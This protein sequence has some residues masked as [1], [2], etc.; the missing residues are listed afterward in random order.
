MNILIP[1]AGAGSRFSQAGY[2]L[3]K[4]LIDVNGKPM[5]QVVTGNLNM[6]AK[7]TYVVQQSHYEQYDLEHLLNLIS[8]GCNIVQV[9]GLTEGT[10]CTTLLARAF[11]DNDEPLIIANSDQ[12]I[13][14]D[15]NAFLDAMAADDLDGGIPTFEATSSKWCYAKLDEDGLVCEVVEKKPVSRF[16]A[17]GIFYW[18]HGNDYVR[19]TEDMIAKD[20]RTNNE[21][22]V[23]PA[24]NE[25]IADN[26]RIKVYDVR[27]MWSL[28]TPEDLTDYL[29]KHQ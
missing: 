8:P 20:I 9:D 23:S 5:I 22:F 14:W 2:S 26:K 15:S 13:E 12:Y 18:K 10:A 16:A 19:Y 11:I 29:E 24:Y 25:A 27:K 21:F 28:G 1:M 7:H 4:P 17:V 6:A 3:P